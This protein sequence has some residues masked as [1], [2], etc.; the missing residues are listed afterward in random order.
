M[1]QSRHAGLLSNGG[2]CEIRRLGRQIRVS[3]PAFRGRQI[4]DL[5]G[6]Q[7][8]SKGQIV[9]TLTN[10][11]LNLCKDRDGGRQQSDSTRGVVLA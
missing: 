9:L 6:S 4:G 2:S 7:T 10:V 1:R 3:N 8:D 5:G 11:R